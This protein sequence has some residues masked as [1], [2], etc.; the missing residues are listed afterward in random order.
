MAN[1]PASTLS[2]LM[3]KDTRF[4]CICSIQSQYCRTVTIK[5]S[6]ERILARYR[7]ESKMDTEEEQ[8]KNYGDSKVYRLSIPTAEIIVKTKR[9]SSRQEVGNCPGNKRTR[10]VFALI[11]LCNLLIVVTYFLLCLYLYLYL[12]LYLCLT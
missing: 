11:L 6:R 3:V 10:R 8:K 7:Q 4:S 2:L 5:W 12:Y 1:A 9:D